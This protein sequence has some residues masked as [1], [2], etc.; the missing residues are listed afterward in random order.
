MQAEVE[1]EIWEN[2]GEDLDTMVPKCDVIVLNTLLTEKTRG[3]FNKEKI[4]KLEKDT[5]AIVDACFSG[6]TVKEEFIKVGK[7]MRG[8]SQV[9]MGNPFCDG[10]GPLGLRKSIGRFITPIC[11][12]HHQI[13]IGAENDKMSPK[14]VKLAIRR[15]VPDTL[16]ENDRA[17]FI[18]IHGYWPERSQILSGEPS[19]Q[20]MGGPYLPDDD[21]QFDDL[22]EKYNHHILARW[23]DM[24]NPTSIGAAKRFVMREWKK[25]GKPFGI[26]RTMYLYHGLALVSA[27]PQN[28]DIPVGV[29]MTLDEVGWRAQAVLRDLHLFGDHIGVGVLPQ[30][31]ANMDPKNPKGPFLLKEI[32]VRLER[33]LKE[34]RAV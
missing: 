10:I 2:F 15:F 12:G 28:F 31:V 33:I 14:R 25:H 16:G 11:K 3:M 29:P 4:A 19:Q 5:Q 20:T 27:I 18:V 7:L 17:N 9:G 32:R 22:C 1:K 26:S 30:I 21:T 13:C 23:P 6:Y 8:T 24:K 34:E